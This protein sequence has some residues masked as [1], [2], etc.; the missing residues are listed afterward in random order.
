V[1][2][3]STARKSRSETGAAFHDYLRLQN[4]WNPKNPSEPKVGE[5]NPWS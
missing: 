2:R 4:P 1:N 5:A 3:K